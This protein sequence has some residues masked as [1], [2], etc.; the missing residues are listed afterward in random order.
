[1][2][3]LP[4][5]P[6]PWFIAR[7]TSNEKYHFDSVAGRH[8]VLCFFGSAAPPLSA[9]VLAG[10]LAR[11]E[12]FDDVNAC[13]F[14]VSVDPEDER[15]GRVRELL[16]G[17][18][19][20]W[21]FDRSLSRNFGIASD[22]APD[23]TPVTLLLDERLRVVAALPFATDAGAHVAEVMRLLSAQPPVGAARPE[24]H[25]PVLLVPGVFEPALCRRLIALYEAQGGKDSGVMRERAGMTVGEYDHAF[26]RRRDQEVDD[27]KLRQACIARIERRLVPEIERAFAFRATRIER[28]IVACYDAASGGFFRPHRD[29]RARA[30]AHRRFAVTLNLNTGEYAG[31][32]LRFPEFGPRTYSVGAGGAIVF[33]CSMLHEAT[34]VT[35]GRRFA[36]L[37]FLY[38]D[39][40]AKIREEN[41]RFLADDA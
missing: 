25:A 8:V 33:S 18:R 13:F 15:Q 9:A 22:A 1:M 34:P 16:P 23:Y 6:A 37:P 41:Q 20:F 29:N 35:S 39:A 3:L 5:D 17:Y 14:G 31:G 40:A 28:H 27:A 12:A 11:R 26:K 4:G 38:D 19:W 2:K 36:Y 32:E 10:F 24:R 30:T 21:D 7:C